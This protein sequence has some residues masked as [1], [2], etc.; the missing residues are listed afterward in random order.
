MLNH[1]VTFDAHANSVMGLQAMSI[2]GP[3]QFASFAKDNTVKVWSVTT[4]KPT[5]LISNNR[6]AAVNL[7]PKVVLKRQIRN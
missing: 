1:L 3:N 5:E 4:Q 6:A 7:L 2:N